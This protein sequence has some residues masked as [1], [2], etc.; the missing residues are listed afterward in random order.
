MKSINIKYYNFNKKNLNN[1]LIKNRKKISEIK[2]TIL[3][4]PAL[5][6]I[7]DKKLLDK[8]I[9]QAKKFAVNKKNFL[10]FGTGGSNLG[11]K[12]LVGILQNKEKKNVNFYDNIDPIYF[13]NLIEKINI[14]KEKF[15]FI[16]ISKSGL[17][18]ET[19]SQFVALIEFFDKKNT[20][21]FFLKNCLIITE[22]NSN[23]LR[24]IAEKHG[25]FI[26]D[27]HSDIGG[28]FSVFSNVGLIP[29]VIAGFDAVKFYK[30]ANAVLSK[31]K[32]NAFNEHII[33]AKLFTTKKIAK[34]INI[35][36]IMTYSDSLFYFGKWYLQLWAES[37]G[38]KGIG[39]TPIHSVGTTDQ[40][41]QL[42]LYLD[43]PRD[44]FFSFITTN[45]S[46]L[47]LKINKNALAK[48]QSSYLAGKFMGDLMEAEQK[49]IINT[50]KEKKLILRQ[51]HLSS[52]DEFSI[53]ELMALSILETIATCNF[54]NVN[55][56]NQPAV[57]K[58]K[59]LTKNYLSRN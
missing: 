54:L 59:K 56:F 10:I 52:I 27:H 11:S 20:L 53:G 43:G 51:I 6:I 17:T 28:R 58:G 1:S 49:A 5:N 47:G 37:I 29:A 16:I 57:E 24:K 15:G 19:L 25:C 42:Q 12:A 35:N 8:T 26:V 13:K 40:H 44:K 48:T 33:T 50:F 39:I 14:K 9:L 46:K 2:N 41:S 23:P 36:V 34:K 22:K 55:P 7:S 18:P 31:L 38:K 3:N 21:K 30:G 32:N 4:L 45:H